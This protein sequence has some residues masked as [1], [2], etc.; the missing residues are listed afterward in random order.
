M[1]VFMQLDVRDK[2]LGAMLAMSPQA[3]KT[4]SRAPKDSPISIGSSDPL[5]LHPA[6]SDLRTS[7]PG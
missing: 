3:Y 1:Q 6:T 7:Y 2:L 4:R 5:Q